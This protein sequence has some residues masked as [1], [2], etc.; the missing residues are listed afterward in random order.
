[1]SCLLIIAL[2]LAS[3]SKEK[4]TDTKKTTKPSKTEF[5]NKG[6]H[7]QKQ[8]LE[9]QSGQASPQSTKQDKEKAEA[10]FAIFEK[11]HKDTI[12]RRIRL[13]R[14]DKD[15]NPRYLLSADIMKVID[16]QTI[17]AEY[18]R[19]ELY[20]EDGS[21]KARTKMG[22]A[23][24]KESTSTLEAKEAI[25]IDGPGFKVSGSGLVYD[26]KTERGFVLGPASTLFQIEQSDSPTKQTK[27]Q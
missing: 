17:E 16:A 14:Y 19:L 2:G 8:T 24:Y 5:N 13:P 3:C 7:V 6:S 21:I 1:M 20:N 12:L 26:L 4:K 18:I 15:F 9:T 23:I 10:S 25:Y 11:L 22:Q 27:A